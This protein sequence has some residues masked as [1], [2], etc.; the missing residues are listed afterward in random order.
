MLKSLIGKRKSPKNMG[1]DSHNLPENGVKKLYLVFPD[2]KGKPM[3]ALEEAV[4][5][6]R[7]N[8]DAIIDR[9]GVSSRHCTLY[10]NQDV[11]SIVDHGS[12]LGTFVNG[13]RIPAGRIIILDPKDKLKAGR[14]SFHIESRY[15]EVVEEQDF[16][17]SHTA[18]FHVGELSLSSLS[19][20]ALVETP[21]EGGDDEVDEA[22]E[23]AETKTELG[24]DSELPPLPAEEVE[25]EL[26]KAPGKNR[27]QIKPS[28]DFSVKGKGSSKEAANG[29]L[30]AMGL[31]F[32]CLVIGLIHSLASGSGA[33]R[34]FAQ[35]LPHTL[36]SFTEPVFNEYAKPLV[37]TAFESLPELGNVAKLGSTFLEEGYFFLV[38]LAILLAVFRLVCSVVFGVSLGQALAGIRAEGSFITKRLLAPLRWLMGALFLP[39][40]WIADFPTLFS[41]RSLKEVMSF[42]RLETPSSLVAALSCIIFAPALCALLLTSPLWK[43]LSLPAPIAFA[44]L[45]KVEL[46]IF[47]ASAIDSRSEYFEIGIPGGKT[48]YFLPLF[49]FSQKGSIKLLQPSFILAQNER[50][51]MEIKLLKRTDLVKLYTSFALHNPFSQLGYPELN[52]L[53]RDAGNVSKSFKATSF[54]EVQVAKDFQKLVGH[55]LELTPKDPGKILT[56]LQNNGPF[57]GPLAGFRS[58]LLA[59][60]GEGAKSFQIKQVGD[61]LHLIGDY[62]NGKKTVKRFLPLTG[63]KA[64]LYEVVYEKG[65]DPSLL[66]LLA[67]KENKNTSGLSDADPLVSFVDTFVPGSSKEGIYD[68]YQAAAQAYFEL[69]KAALLRSDAKL[70]RGV[71]RSLEGSLQALKNFSAL[72]IPEEAANKMTQNLSDILRALNERDLEY[73]GVSAVGDGT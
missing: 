47:D 31:I 18:V 51:T 40:F 73:F 50:D 1:A 36:W 24:L 43:S 71:Q 49:S 38:E 6:G 66:E 67:W 41:R 34:I 12:E 56:L 30:R 7:D 5:V 45:A 69:S 55:A 52:A 26:A 14:V 33:Y 22:L 58:E 53:A 59:L 42:T 4:T 11:I 9:E 32:D 16:A 3:F 62:S 2:V 57:L 13:K 27:G 17:D 64:N 54:K 19:E 20:S 28:F 70:Y 15:E 35:D 37:D 8:S 39:F 21:L 60:F 25:E 29:F 48:L 46:G 61:A 72:K 68:T 63:R 23:A 44:P 65:S 10:L